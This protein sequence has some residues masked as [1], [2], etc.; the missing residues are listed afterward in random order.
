M[1]WTNDYDIY[2]KKVCQFNGCSGNYEGPTCE[3]ERC[4]LEE[5]MTQQC[6]C[7]DG[8]SG[9]SVCTEPNQQYSR[10]LFNT[11]HPS[12]TKYCDV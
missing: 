3:L 7:K 11:V 8:K 1:E 2:G 12:S 4:T 10:C 5:G 6:K 9:Y